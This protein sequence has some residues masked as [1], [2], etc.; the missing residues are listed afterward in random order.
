MLRQ[1]LEQTHWFSR[2]RRS[3]LRLALICFFGHQ[4][5]L[6]QDATTPG[7]PISP[8]PTLHNLAVE[9]PFAGDANSNGIVTVQYRRTGEPA[10]HHAMP[11]RRIAAGRW[12]ET[13][14]GRTTDREFDWD[15]KHSGSV[16]D[17]RAGTEYEIALTLTDPDGGSTKRTLKIR[18]RPVPQAAPDARIVRVNPGNF[19]E[20]ARVAKPGDLLLLAPGNYGYFAAE[21]DGEAGRPIVFRADPDG[22]F[23]ATKDGLGMGAA[24][25]EGVSL[26]NRRHVHLE[27]I[28]SSGTI[29]LFNADSCVVR[30]CRIHAVFGIVSGYTGNLG[31][32]WA[33]GV[34]AR[35]RPPATPELWVT[36]DGRNLPPGAAPRPF[37]TN[38]Y[39]ADNVILGMT[40]W[41][42]EAMGA[43][44]KNMGEGIELTG[45]GNVICHN[46]V[47]GFRDCIST[48]E[49]R[50]VVNQVCIDIYN[51]DV[52]RGP[53]DGIEAD[54]TQGNCRIMRNRITNC[55]MGVSSQPSLGG[56]SYI[57]RNVMYNIVH[58]AYK[59]VRDSTGNVVLHNTVVRS[60]DG[61]D[62]Y[63]ERARP[64]MHDSIFRNNL[65]IH[66]GSAAAYGGSR[67]FAI[68]TG[69]AVYYPVADRTSS[70]DYNG[71]GAESMPFRGQ[72]GQRHFD[73]LESMRAQGIE[74]HG[75]RV[76]LDIF[77]QPVAIPEPALREWN[78][79]DLRLKAG[80]GATDAGVLLPNIN[81]DYTGRAPDLGAYE[82]G[83]E[84]PV[85]GPRPPG[86]D[87]SIPCIGY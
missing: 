37:A 61:P 5:L 17:L 4:T 80:S 36:V 18:T 29:D 71:Y 73:S 14:D 38:C 69:R 51:N 33:P 3:G 44:G 8:Y 68:G 2:H 11:L 64:D 25:F 19:T 55:F 70:F 48:L 46:R 84:P 12:T 60:G 35:L 39:V 20:A 82:F 43:A 15:N 47:S 21:Q 22:R 79:P 87:E 6:A 1:N 10:W 27:G 65:S 81:D 16:F 26:Q 75:V 57:I 42:S 58:S 41:T 85:Y 23:S 62:G 83:R 67:T 40:E 9:W 56:P 77:A 78:P 28:F 32:K 63:S 59:F 30:R 52:S 72:V 24:L 13:R 86:A 50:Y 54:F 7:E 66:G 34:A 53:D 45:P 74:P 31:R 76:G 49:D